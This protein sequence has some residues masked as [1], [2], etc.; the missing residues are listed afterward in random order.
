MFQRRMILVANRLQNAQLTAPK[1]F[2][3]SKKKKQAASNADDDAVDNNGDAA[4]VAADEENVAAQSSRS[5]IEKATTTAST[6]IKS[7]VSALK[8][9]DTL[10]FQLRNKSLQTRR[11]FYQRLK[12]NAIHLSFLVYLAVG[13]AYYALDRN[14]QGMQNTPGSHAIM[15]YYESITVGFSVGLGTKD[16]NYM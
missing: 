7:S 15:G 5:M 1:L 8:D 13:T 16:P 10:A 9:F 2:S 11:N 4:A 12:R 3:S 6:A 14:N